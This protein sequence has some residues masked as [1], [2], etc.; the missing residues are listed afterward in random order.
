MSYA[1]VQ[2]ELVTPDVPALTRAFC[3]LVDLTTIDAQNAANDAFGILWRGLDAERAGMLQAALEYEGIATEVVSEGEFPALA[4]PHVI[5]QAEITSEF[6]VA[7]DSMQRPTNIPWSEV[8]LLAAGQV[9]TRETHRRD[10]LEDTDA[11]HATRTREEEHER[12]VI[13]LF[14]LDRTTRYN[15]NADEFKFAD[16]AGAGPEPEPDLVTNFMEL[17]GELV[18]RLPQASLNQ[19]AFFAGQ[20]PPELFRYPSRQAYQEEIVWLLWRIGRLA[21]AAG[22]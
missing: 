10:P 2:K 20:N 5:R 18:R 6:L 22:E 16:A 19:G 7:Y 15:I 8:L 4:T 3:T 17:L 1:I 14:L 9:H 12:L 21:A 11:V 13:D